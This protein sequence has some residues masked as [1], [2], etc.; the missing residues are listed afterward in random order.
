MKTTHEEI[1]D[2]KQLEL[3]ANLFGF[4]SCLAMIKFVTSIA[5]FSRVSVV[6][7]H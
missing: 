4:V 5:N 3:L 1:L 7:S 6:L 2:S